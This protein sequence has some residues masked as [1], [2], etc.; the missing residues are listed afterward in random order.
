MQ[1]S[2]DIFHEIIVKITFI[3]RNKELQFNFFDIK[4][5]FFNAL[6]CMVCLNEKKILCNWMPKW[7]STNAAETEMR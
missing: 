4:T 7:A 5:E 6:C 1:F 3:A 2:I